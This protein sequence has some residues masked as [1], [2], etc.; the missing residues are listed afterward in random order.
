MTRRHV[1][2][3]RTDRPVADHNACLRVMSGPHIDVSEVGYD[4]MKSRVF[5]NACVRGGFA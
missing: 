4:F 1:T 3:N 5:S 2:E